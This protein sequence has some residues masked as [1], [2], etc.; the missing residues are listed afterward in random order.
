MV[1]I[2]L[3]PMA[4]SLNES[5]D[6]QLLLP[7]YKEGNKATTRMKRCVQMIAAVASLSGPNGGSRSA[8]PKRNKP[9]R[10]S[11]NDARSATNTRFCRN[12]TY[13]RLSSHDRLTAPFVPSNHDISVRRATRLEITDDVWLG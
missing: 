1:S 3:M 13:P 11:V 2:C 9:A 12:W 8:S 10:Y 4:S 5:E 6:K 7:A